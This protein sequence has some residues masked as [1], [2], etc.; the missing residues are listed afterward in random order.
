[1]FPL[2]ILQPNLLPILQPNLTEINNYVYAIIWSVFYALYPTWV[3]VCYY[4]AF[5]TRQPIWVLVILASF[6]FSACMCVCVCVRV[7]RFRD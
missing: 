7:D 1:M 5:P 2:P 6:Y 3:I 4:Y